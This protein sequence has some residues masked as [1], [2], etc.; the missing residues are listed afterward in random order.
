M[1]R[2]AL[3]ILAVAGVAACASGR[4]GSALYRKDIGTASLRDA[5]SLGLRIA[6]QF[7]YEIFQI[8]TVTEIRILT[9]WKTRRPFADELALGV[10]SAETRMLIV[11]RQR[12]H[13]D[14]GSIYNVNVTLENRVQVAGSEDWN[15][16]LNTEMFRR[17]ADEI[18][19]EYRKLITAIGVRKF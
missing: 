1:S 9:H 10:T 5:V 16:S 2:Q 6:Q 7:H 12:G 11:G 8:D 13:T 17:H 18:T 15:E 19:G 14:M 3:L 4:G